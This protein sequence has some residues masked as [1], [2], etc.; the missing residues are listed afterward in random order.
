MPPVRIDE[1]EPDLAAENFGGP[2]Q[3][4]E[5][6]IAVGGVEKPADLATAGAHTLG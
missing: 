3:S 2:L 5:G 4:G 1:I 6:D